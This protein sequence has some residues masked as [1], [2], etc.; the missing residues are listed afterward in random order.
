MDAFGLRLISML[1]DT[2]VPVPQAFTP[3]TEIFAVAAAN[4][5]MVSVDEV[6]MGVAATSGGSVQ[7]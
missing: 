2:G 7:V 3:A 6:L 1:V 4:A 5:L